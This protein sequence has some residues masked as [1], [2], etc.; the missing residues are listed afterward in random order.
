MLQFVSIF[1]FTELG[2]TFRP[3]SKRERHVPSYRGN[4]ATVTILGFLPVK[5][6]MVYDAF[7]AQHF[8]PEAR[9]HSSRVWYTG[10][11]VDALMAWL[12]LCMNLR[13]K[14]VAVLTMM[15]SKYLPPFDFWLVICKGGTTVLIWLCYIIVCVNGT[16]YMEH[17]CY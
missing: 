4:S 2:L 12:V 15:W 17:A 11:A 7:A 8:S 1:H 10:L 16:F 3:N 14:S 5:S 13:T 6:G 9:Y